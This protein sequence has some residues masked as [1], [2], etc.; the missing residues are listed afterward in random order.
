MGG[1]VPVSGGLC[2]SIEAARERRVQA[3]ALLQAADAPAH[4]SRIARLEQ[5]VNALECSRGFFR[6]LQ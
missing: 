4:E 1:S 6:T 3:G 5:L 2:H